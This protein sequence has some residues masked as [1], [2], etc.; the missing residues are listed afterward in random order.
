MAIKKSRKFDREP[1]WYKD[2][3][4]YELHIKAFM[5]KNNDGIGDFE[6]LFEK[7]DYLENL[8]VTTI[9]LLPFYPSPQRDDGYDIS[10]YKTINPAYGVLADFKKFLK[11][12]HNRNLKVI[13]E[14][15]MNHTSDQHE[16]F[17]RSRRAPKG[18]PEREYYV[19]SDD[20]EKFK[21]VRII[22]P[23]YEV[24]NWTWDPVADQ[25]YWHRFFHH[26]PDLNYH[27]PLVQKEMLSIMD[28]W[29]A[30]GVD[31]F[32]LDAIPYL[33]EEE[34]TTCDNLPHTHEFLKKLRKNVDD[35]YDNVLL[36]AEANMWP[37]DSA[38]YFGKGD[39]CH[40]NF[41]FP[42]MPRLFMAVNMEDRFPIIDVIEQTPEIPES[43]QWATFLRNHDELTLEMVTEEERD[44]MYKVYTKDPLARINLGIRK[45][46]A[47]RNHQLL[48]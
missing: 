32:R 20:P 10:D 22:F 40:M 44:Y 27:N 11:E 1:L 6:G 42:I 46:L 29:L 4:I 47:T 33:F 39:E 17:Q 28:Y 35:K 34:G 14:L 16:W 21:G 19:W 30:M 8:G 2:A 3:I 36:L 23:D 18:S 43:C 41:Y 12:A 9:W 38:S 13:I 37:E 5:D 7:L 26:Q 15:V 25:Y 48:K 45:R 31:G 24:S